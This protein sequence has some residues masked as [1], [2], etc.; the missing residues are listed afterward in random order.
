[1]LYFYT[2]FSSNEIGLRN[3]PKKLNL[4]SLKK[5]HPPQLKLLLIPAA[6]VKLLLLI[7]K[8]VLLKCSVNV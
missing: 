8:N 1:M 3:D 6:N 2:S 5:K 7:V 4:A